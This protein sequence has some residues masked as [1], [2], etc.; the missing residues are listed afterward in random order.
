M[1]KF[2]RELH[3]PRREVEDALVARPRSLQ[4]LVGTSAGEA[5]AEGAARLDAGEEVAGDPRSPPAAVGRS[6][7]AGVAR[8]G[9]ETATGSG[10]PAKLAGHCARQEKDQRVAWTR[11]PPPRPALNPG[12]DEKPKPAPDV[13]PKPKPGENP[14]RLADLPADVQMFVK[15]Q[16]FPRLTLGERGRLKAAEGKWPEFPQTIRKLADDHPVLPPGPLGE[17][18]EYKQ[19]PPAISLKYKKD[20]F[21]TARSRWPDYAL[22]VTRIVKRKQKN[23]PPLG[24]SKLDE[25][26]KPVQIFVREKLQPALSTEQKKSLRKLEGH[27]PE[28]PERLLD[29]ARRKR[30][31][32]PGMSLPG[33]SELWGGRR[34]GVKRKVVRQKECLPPRMRLGVEIS[35]APIRMIIE[36]N[37][38]P[39]RA[40]L[41]IASRRRGRFQDGDCPLGAAPLGPQERSHRHEQ[42]DAGW[43]A[44]RRAHRHCR[45]RS[46]GDRRPARP[47]PPVGLRRQ[48]T[49]PPGPAIG[50]RRRPGRSRS[51]QSR[52]HRVDTKADRQR[53]SPGRPRQSRL[54]RPGRRRRRADED[55][56]VLAVRRGP[57]VPPSRPPRP[58]N[59]GSGQT[60]R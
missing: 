38:R 45:R 55:R 39:I 54:Q 36:R 19:L 23:V 15:N 18:T 40:V 14:K 8:A 28:Y 49:P 42:A 35:R 7:A 53:S 2:D 6:A 21:F 31:V 44:V 12:P 16:L 56:A 34:G 60:P 3:R 10:V 43:R 59:S 46:R 29:L 27:W 33:P 32:I 50:V 51:R 26:P 9:A 58:A 11:V 48:R 25:F 20:R 41:S 24:A 30:L 5:A 52:R 22:A 57:A 1:R 13:K 37:K 4:H 47:A 17:I